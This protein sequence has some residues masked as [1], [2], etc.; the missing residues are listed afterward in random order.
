VLDLVAIG[1]GIG[2]LNAWQVERATARADVAVRSLRPVA[3]HDEFRVAWQVGDASAETAAL[4]R[5]VLET[6]A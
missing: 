1:T 2:W 3:L 6:C 5:V 4:V